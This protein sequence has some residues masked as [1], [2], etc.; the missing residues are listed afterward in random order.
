MVEVENHTK[1]CDHCLDISITGF[2]ERFAHAR[3]K[4][5]ESTQ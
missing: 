3:G 1:I 2:E 4:R 5:R